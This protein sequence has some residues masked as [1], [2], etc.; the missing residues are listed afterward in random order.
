M[1]SQTSG[2]SAS[3][4]RVLLPLA[5]VAAVACAAPSP[6]PTL[7]P[8]AP[9]RPPPSPPEAPPGPKPATEAERAFLACVRHRESG[10]NYR[11]VSSNDR[12][13]GAYQFDRE[14]WNGVARH[15]GRN[16]LVGVAPNRAS[17]A[18]QDAMALAL[19][20]WRGTEPWNG[21]CHVTR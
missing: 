5:L 19:Y 1:R 10:Q 4:V 20:R 2:A 21:K 12:Y 6:P 11:V 13:F 17:D 3:R 9:V 15:A 14:T 18:D 16:D 8:P 7:P